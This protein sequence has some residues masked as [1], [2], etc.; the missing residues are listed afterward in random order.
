MFHAEKRRLV[1]HRRTVHR[2]RGVRRDIRRFQQDNAFQRQ[3]FFP[4]VKITTCSRR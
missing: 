1:R 4:A 2:A 3:R